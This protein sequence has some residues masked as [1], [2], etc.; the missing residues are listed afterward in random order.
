MIRHGGGHAIVSAVA[1]SGKTAT[2]IERISFLLDQGVPVSRILVLLFNKNARDDFAY[3]LKARLSGKPSPEIFTYHSFGLRLCKALVE[4]GRLPVA[5]LDSTGRLTLKLA[6]SVLME[7]NE[8]LSA[9]EQ[10]D[11]GLE[12]VREF[13]EVVDVLK[14]SLYDGRASLPED[15]KSFPEKTKVAYRLFEEKRTEQGLRSFT[16]L[17]YDPIRLANDDPLVSRYLS[18][19]YDHI[20]VDEFQ[21]ANLVQVS[22]I[23]HLAGSRA[24][25]MVVG[26]EDQTIYRWRGARPD[27]MTHKFSEIFPQPARYTLPHTYRYGKDLAELANNVIQNNQQRVHKLCVSAVPVNTEVVLQMHQDNAGMNVC[28]EI[29]RWTRKGNSLKDVAILVREFNNTIP[30]EIMLQD[31]RIPY[32]LE[33]AESFVDR[34]ESMVIR[35]YLQLCLPGGLAGCNLIEQRKK[36]A[37]SLLSYPSLYLRRDEMEMIVESAE[38]DLQNFPSVAT[39]LLKGLAI[40][41]KAFTI[42][43]RMTVAEGW[44]SCL[45]S[46]RKSSAARFLLGIYRKLDLFTAIRKQNPRKEVADDK[47]RLLHNMIR[48][49]ESG[50]HTIESFSSYLNEVAAKVRDADHTQESVLLTSIHRA[51]GMEWL[52]VIMPDLAEGLFPKVDEESEDEIEDERRLFYVGVTRAKQ[53]LAMIAPLDPHLITAS[54]N[55]QFKTPAAGSFKASRF[56]YEARVRA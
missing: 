35:A 2:M 54:M 20:I 25:V 50:R 7:V 46:D 44:A 51:K 34:P 13:L 28:A 27:Y 45:S 22:M 33:G 9:D 19:R 26:D 43:R 5:N 36:M 8:G 12:Y 38:S 6:R 18:N 39:R 41:S 49:A 53:R 3:R 55:N 21:D 4:T 17:V 11:L 15:I 48:L 52:F 1:G 29:A 47:I 40:G 30:V 23:Q 32:R 10:F 14:N 16:D 37:Y 24:K 56:L 42:D 31:K